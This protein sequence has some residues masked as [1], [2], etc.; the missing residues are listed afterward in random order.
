MVV[1]ITNIQSQTTGRIPIS[2]KVSDSTGEPLAG[3]SVSV[4]GSGGTVTDSNGNY[5]INVPSTEST[6]V[7]SYVGYESQREKAG[8][9]T[10]IDI[11]LQEDTRLLDEVV[12]VGYG[13]QR[14][15]DITGSVVSFKPSQIEDMPQTNVV[16][17]LQG[18]IAGVQITNVSSSVEGQDTKIRVRA[19]NSINADASPLVVLDGI[20]Y[21]GFLSE[22]NPADIESIEILKDASSAAIYGARAANGVMLI[23]T[24][25]GT[26]GKA[27]INFDSFLGFDEYANLPDMMNGEQFYNFKKERLGYVGSFEQ[28]QYDLGR[29]T[30]WVDLATQT[31]VR[32][33]YNLSVSGGNESTSYFVAANIS[34]LKGIAINDN[35]DRY[36][37]RVNLETRIKPWLKFGTNTQL[38][39]YNRPGA[40]AN[41]SNAMKMS[42][43]TIPYREDGSI[44]YHPW[45]DDLN[46]TNPLEP[47]NYKKEDIARS[48]VTTNYLHVDFPFLK[49]LSYRIIGG[50]NYRYRLIEQYRAI[51]NTLEGEQKGG[52]AQVNNQGKE[53]WTLENILNYNYS[54][55]KHNL[56]VTAVYSA[57][58]YTQKYH[59][60]EGVGFP[61]DYMTY[62]QFKLATTL[63]PED[64]YVKTANL[65]QMLRL[66]Y[67]FDNRYLMTLTARRDGYSA[68]GSDTKFGIFPSA[69]LGWNLEQESFM[70][71]T[72]SWMDRL[73]L[74]LS[75]GENGNQ[76]ISAYTALPTM[77][78][79]YYLDNDKNPLIGFYSNKLADPTLSWE[80]TRQFNAGIDYS[81]LKGRFYGSIDAYKANTYD[82]LLNKQ[83]PQINGV[84]SIRQNI[85]QTGSYG[86]EFQI[87]SVNIKT[88]DFTWSTDFNI[89]HNRNKIKNVGLFDGNGKAMDNLGNRWF[90]GKPINVVYAY[91]FDGIW[92]EGDDI[93]NS[94]M[95]QSKPGDVRVVDRS[96]PDG[97]PDGKITTED[98]DIIGYKDP[99]F[100]AG[101]MNT[102]SYKGLTFSFFLNAVNGVTRYTEYT[103]TY[104]DGKSNIRQREWW[105]PENKLNTYPANRDD[106]NPYGLTYFG[107]S[108]D[109]SYIRLSDVTLSYKLPKTILDKIGFNRLEIFANAKN[110]ATFTNYIGLDPEITSDYAVPLTRSYIFGLRFGL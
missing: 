12:V 50:Y 103:N 110:L 21:S 4:P 32:Q 55:S 109:A 85:G 51:S 28:E 15:S 41:F 29:N 31:G 94:H 38:G 60:N 105:T 48:V 49:G 78:N 74:R 20:P 39:Y 62:Y 23:T 47:L 9:R 70:E 95:P 83:I 11:R 77:S 22:I 79:E 63:S 91:V 99:D 106:S 14:K 1:F 18:K 8:N 17:S 86:I 56:N 16:Q 53:D 34:D 102:L 37:L 97:V 73:K 89:S 25:K 52:V 61:G 92:Q 27:R 84:S 59:D 75:Y 43:L 80:T 96:G 33:E 13:T 88:K 42:P 45:P 40:K 72:G 82:L 24:K 87:S 81:F 71:S 68:F 44:E 76:A 98:M 3:V 64:S 101:M 108:N 6:L 19:Q 35:Y 2:G 93:A 100:V 30:K 90:I 5:K 58:Q 65:S 46:T 66:N 104:F 107:K 26:T 10:Q 57:Q 7:F 69:A 54:I 36:T 67:T